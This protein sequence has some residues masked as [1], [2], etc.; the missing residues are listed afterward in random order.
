MS[1]NDK[2][3]RMVREYT[4]ETGK[5]EVTT[6]E[7]AEWAI[8]K[9]LWKPHKSDLVDQF[10]K[11]IARAMREEYITDPQGRTIRAK[12]AARVERGGDQLTLWADIRK[13]PSKHMKIAFQQRRHQI[14]GDCR[15]LKVDVDSYNENWSEGTSIQMSFDFTRDLEEIE[16]A[17]VV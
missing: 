6:H 10:A 12:H 3:Q 5:S 13:A 2:L 4:A 1:Y 14:V 16:A 7:V 17:G 15:Q 9:G 8:R 11:Q